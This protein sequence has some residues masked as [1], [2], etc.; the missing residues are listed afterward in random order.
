MRLDL[1]NKMVPNLR[2]D[3]FALV[4]AAREPVVK[5]LGLLLCAFLGILVGPEAPRAYVGIFIVVSV[6]VRVGLSRER[7][8]RGGRLSIL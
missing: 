1:R 6:A 2:K 7:C 4:D 3:N 8:L 5:L